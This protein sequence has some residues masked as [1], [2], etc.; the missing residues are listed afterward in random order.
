MR[1]SS[2]WPTKLLRSIIV[3]AIFLARDASDAQQPIAAAAN[4][5]QASD[6]DSSATNHFNQLM[7]QLVLNNMPHSYADD[8][9]WG[10]TQQ[11]FGGIQLRRDGWNVET[12]R[13]W[14]TVNHGLWQKS[15]AHLVD[16][17][18]QF[19][20]QLAN[21]RAGGDDRTAFDLIFVSPL[22]ISGRQ[23][24]WVNGVQLYSVSADADAK[25]RLT[26]TC[27]MSIK[28]DFQRLPP[29]V[30]FEPRATAADLQVEHFAVKHISKVGGEVAEQATQWVESQLDE[31]VAAKESKIVD[32]INKQIAK[33]QDEMRISLSDALSSDWK[34]IFWP[35]LTDSLKRDVQALPTMPS[36][37]K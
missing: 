1:R 2:G 31:Q 35:H 19:S 9:R 8:K 11:R 14:V 3:C 4:A 36:P 17:A 33:H 26:V 24:Q 32:K 7:T 34:E 25:I 12:K 27:E 16:P 30:V 28:L 23:A 15:S 37:N 18:N 5:A 13:K 6:V 22:A 29:D 10:K 20:V 21:V